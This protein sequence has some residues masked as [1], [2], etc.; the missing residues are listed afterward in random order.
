MSQKMIRP[1]VLAVVVLLAAFGLAPQSAQAQ[2]LRIVGSST[3]FPFSALV[4]EYWGRGLLRRTPVV[5]STGTGGGMKLFC[6]EASSSAPDMSNA[7]RRIKAS[8]Y[9]SCRSR[10][11]RLMEVM[12]GYDGVVVAN[13]QR[14]PVLDLSLRQLYLALAQQ[15]PQGA[16]ETAEA[17]PMQANPH[18]RWSDIDR[19]LPN[20]RIEVLGPPPTS[21]TRDAFLE[22]VMEAG[23]KSFP[24]LA[25][26]RKADKQAFRRRAHTLREDGAWIDAGEN[27]NLIVQKLGS[28]A[29]A[30][31]VFGFS[32]L[33]ENRDLVKGAK[34]GGTP[35]SFPLIADGSYPVSRS[36][37]VYVRLDGS[38]RDENRQRFMQEFLSEEAMDESDGYLVDR[39]LIPLPAAMLQTM[40]ARLRAMEELRM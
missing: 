9:Q 32:F 3:V 38:D 20:M 26:L 33:E 7:S 6:A 5:E 12:V 40:R 18:R 11:I 22:L 2:A 17:C 14:G 31:G 4:A 15:V 21:G 37:Y 25:A 8:E 16:C 39:G 10:N 24:G 30:L 23:A 19:A 36:L 1:S 34:I 13:A 28:N 27:D 29:D 35:P